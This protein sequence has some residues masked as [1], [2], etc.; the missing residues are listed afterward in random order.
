MTELSERKMA[1]ET[2]FKQERNGG[3]CVITNPRKFA[4]D[5]MRRLCLPKRVNPIICSYTL[6]SVTTARTG[7]KL[8]N[9]ANTVTGNE[10]GRMNRH[11]HKLAVEKAETIIF[12]SKKKCEHV[13]ISVGKHPV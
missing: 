9:Y 6:T 13:E 5:G 7:T 11:K 12:T 10:A 4:F 2:M 1:L 8:K 3:F